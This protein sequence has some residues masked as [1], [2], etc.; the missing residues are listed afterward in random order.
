MLSPT[1]KMEH[2]SPPTLRIIV[3]TH[4]L[5]LDWCVFLIGYLLQKGTPS[6]YLASVMYAMMCLLAIGVDKLAHLLIS[7]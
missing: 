3:G 5:C 6:I 7:L 1:G 4:L 2:G